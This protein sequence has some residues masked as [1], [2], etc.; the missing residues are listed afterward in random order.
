MYALRSMSF[1]TYLDVLFYEFVLHLE[2]LTFSSL[3][4]HHSEYFF[5]SCLA[6]KKAESIFAIQFKTIAKCK[7]RNWN[8]DGL[9]SMI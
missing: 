2:L 5:F 3:R 6:Q 1:S 7:K 4:I 9:P 8:F